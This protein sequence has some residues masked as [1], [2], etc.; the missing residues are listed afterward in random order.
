[1]TTIFPLKI[2]LEYKITSFTALLR[3]RKIKALLQKRKIKA[4]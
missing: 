2:A 4:M 3:K 1:M